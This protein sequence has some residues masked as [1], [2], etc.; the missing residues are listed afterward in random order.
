MTI[1]LFGGMNMAI[2]SLKAFTL[3]EAAALLGVDKQSI[4]RLVRAGEIESFRVGRLIRV[5]YRGLD[6][7]V[8]R[9]KTCPKQSLEAL[10][11][12]RRE[13][14]HEQQNLVVASSRG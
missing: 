12:T 7:F 5:T 11:R 2:T 14:A 4:D 6:A 1:Q 3:K 13:G 10:A 8:R 9:S